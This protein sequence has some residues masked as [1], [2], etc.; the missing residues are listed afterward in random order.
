MSEANQFKTLAEYYDML[1]SGVRYSYWVDYLEEIF[2]RNNFEPRSILDVACGTGNVSQI[3]DER[4]YSVIG[5]DIAPDMIDIAKRKEG[6]V[7]YHVSD[8][9]EL[10]LPKKDFDAAVSLFDSV[11]YVTEPEKVK[12]AFKRIA[13]HLKP[14]GMFIFDV[15]TVYALAHKFFDRVGLT[16]T[17]RHV[18]RSSYDYG[19]R[20]CTVDM[21]FQ[22]TE[23][24]ETAE[25]KETHIQR[26]HLPEEL[27]MWLCEAGFETLDI[28][29]AY[30]FRK[31]TRRS[32]RL[33]FV[34]RKK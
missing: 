22:V 9:A 21:T 17:P 15:N 19:T 11:N 16:D 1:M 8:M 23:N 13:G 6:A 2:I 32:D 20:I 31:P 4:G 14:G 5:I 3:L 34:C 18:W 33:F 12:E 10:D 28:F 26:G 24:G 25:F 7:D 29:H 27:S 30:R